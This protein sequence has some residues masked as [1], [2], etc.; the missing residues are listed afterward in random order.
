MR[1]LWWFM[2]GVGAGVWGSLWLLGQAR[3]AKEA[4]T[5]ENLARSAAIAVADTLDRSAATL[6]AR[7]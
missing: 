3:R 7:P 2:L 4:L 6:L 5:P 1:R